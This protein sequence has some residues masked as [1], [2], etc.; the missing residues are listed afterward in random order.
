[1]KNWMLV[2]AVGLFVSGSLFADEA[3]KVRTTNGDTVSVS[4]EELSNAYNAMMKKGRVKNNASGS[5]VNDD[6]SITIK[7]P[8]FRYNG[9]AYPL[10]YS[11][12]SVDR[13]RDYACQFFGFSHGVGS[14]GK[15][16]PP[17]TP[18]IMLKNDGTLYALMSID[19]DY[20][21]I[22]YRI[23]EDLK[24]VLLTVTCR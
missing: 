15:V 6:G 12:S 21:G 10:T 16:M 18:V 8:F 13:D 2:F 20:E 7:N 5:E 24:K 14:E 4:N 11:F 3:T 9:K 22:D 23:P 1:M 19:K 17:K